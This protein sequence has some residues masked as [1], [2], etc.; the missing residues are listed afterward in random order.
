V[1]V[2]QNQTPLAR[3]IIVRSGVL[4]ADI[5][6]IADAAA[7]I[8][9]LPKEYDGRLHWGLAGATLEAA[10]R[11]PLDADL[12]RTATAAME[13]ALA[14]EEMLASLSIPT[15]DA[16]HMPRYG[17]GGR[18]PFPTPAE[19]AEA[20]KLD[21]EIVAC[22]VETFGPLKYIKVA[23]HNGDT[24]TVQLGTNGGYRI[25]RALKAVVPDTPHVGT[26]TVERTEKGYRLQEG[27]MS[28]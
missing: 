13:N 21:R 1:T 25:L 26:A 24:S 9:R 4:A 5:R 20:D 11:H 19:I 2:Q 16:D 7:F 6:T 10:D 17:Q 8:I 14:T 22:S 15:T 27:H 18:V 23:F 12:L 3:P 28:D